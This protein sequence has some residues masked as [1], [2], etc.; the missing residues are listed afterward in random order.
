MEAFQERYQDGPEFAEEIVKLNRKL[1]EYRSEVREIAATQQEPVDTRIQASKLAHQSQAR[2][3][4]VLSEAVSVDESFIPFVDLYEVAEE[5]DPDYSVVSHHAKLLEHSD[6]G[7]YVRRDDLGEKAKITRRDALDEFCK[8]KDITDDC[9]SVI[10]LDRVVIGP[11]P[12]RPIE[13]QLVTVVGPFRKFDRI[14]EGRPQSPMSSSQRTGI[15]SPL[16]FTA[17]GLGSMSTSVIASGIGS[18]T[19]V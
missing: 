11:S 18:R 12:Y 2:I 19:D 1:D 7:A 6:P 9:R 10:A 17:T 13:R 15:S 4:K 8:S 3:L 5:A 14:G 16:R